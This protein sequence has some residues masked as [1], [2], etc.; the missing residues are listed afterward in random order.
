MLTSLELS[1]VRV[2]DKLQLPLA[3]QL[4]ILVGRNNSGKSTVLDSLVHVN[5]ASRS[6]LLPGGRAAYSSLRSNSG[7]GEPC[8][9]VGGRE[10]LQLTCHPGPSLE[11]SRLEIGGGGSTLFED[12]YDSAL[13]RFGGGALGD[14]I[15]DVVSLH[16]YRISSGLIWRDTDEPD[17]DRVPRVSNNGAN[18]A[19]VL[20][21]I[22]EQEP[23]LFAELCLMLSQ[24]VEGFEA[25]RFRSPEP[26]RVQFGI[27]FS[28]RR[29]VV[30]ANDLSDG[31]RSIVCLAAIF[32]H[33]SAPSVTTIEE[34]ENGLGPHSM[35]VLARWLA[36]YTRRSQ[37]LFSTHSPFLLKY[38]LDAVPEAKVYV[39]RQE[40]GIA[41]AYP[42]LDSG[43]EP[44]PQ[45]L[46]AL[47][48]AVDEL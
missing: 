33:P 16:G 34:P 43:A 2:F 27:E 7:S 11:S 9:S 30:W 10:S 38:C 25:L 36:T 13:P 17:P 26:Q 12:S 1:N 4:T 46:E 39:V 6:R 5:I 8:I 22:S 24:A 32:G 3:D 37:L 14:L 29:E 23:E 44:G 48:K 45:S 19:A 28:D 31:T 18:T 41:E 15:G 20:Q 35:R 42:L 21:A 47:A 40:N